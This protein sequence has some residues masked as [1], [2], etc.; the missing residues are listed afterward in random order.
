VSLKRGNESELA[1]IVLQPVCQE[2]ERPAAALCDEA[3]K[4]EHVEQLAAAG[5]KSAAE[6]VLHERLR[7][8][9][10]GLS[11][12]ADKHGERLNGAFPYG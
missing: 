1:L 12:L 11:V 7:P 5:L 9:A 3:G 4:R 2:P 8:D 6:L 10:V